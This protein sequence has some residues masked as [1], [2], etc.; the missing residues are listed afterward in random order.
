M[1]ATNPGQNYQCLHLD[2]ARLLQLWGRERSVW[3]EA[4][5]IQKRTAL[6]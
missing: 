1:V 6:G 3:F 5:K 4:G 2:A